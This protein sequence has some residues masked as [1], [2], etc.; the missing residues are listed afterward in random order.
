MKV[1][2]QTSKLLSHN[3]DPVN[4]RQAALNQIKIVAIV[5]KKWVQFQKGITNFT[6]RLDDQV[7]LIWPS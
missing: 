5:V 4:N 7:N 1:G 6:V 3:A 2:N